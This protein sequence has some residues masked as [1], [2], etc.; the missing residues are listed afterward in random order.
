MMGHP[1]TLAGC[2]CLSFS[3]ICLHAAGGVNGPSVYVCLFMCYG[4]YNMLIWWQCVS[5]IDPCVPHLAA[6]HIQPAET[7]V[8]SG[9]PHAQQTH[10]Q[11]TEALTHLQYEC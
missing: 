2:H 1:P 4:S 6:S 11:S 10:K 8:Q 3:S 5:A 9:D 7:A